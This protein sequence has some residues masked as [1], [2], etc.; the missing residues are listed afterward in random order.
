MLSEQVGSVREQPRS[1]IVTSSQGSHEMIANL[2][3][4]ELGVQHALQNI[5][6]FLIRPLR[7]QFLTICYH[8]IALQMHCVH[9]AIQQIAVLKEARNREFRSAEGNAQNN[10]L[11]DDIIGPVDEM[12]EPFNPLT[13]LITFST[14]HPNHE[15]MNHVIGN[16]VENVTDVFVGKLLIGGGCEHFLEHEV[17]MFRHD[18]QVLLHVR[19]HEKAAHE[20]TISLV[21]ITVRRH[22]TRAECG[23]KFLYILW[24][25][26]KNVAVGQHLLHLIGVQ[27]HD[28][29]FP[30]RPVL[31]DFAVRLGMPTQKLGRQYTILHQ[32]VSYHGPWCRSRNVSQFH[33]PYDHVHRALNDE[34][35]NQRKDDTEDGHACC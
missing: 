15:F 2:E 13:A 8:I 28:H 23:S 22:Q 19:S 20:L 4:G 34:R 29:W 26:D 33:A 17:G 32:H 5:I 1:R 9:I 31:E 24:S 3:L 35:G 7:A 12:R 25:L 6:R 10:G 30:A 21:L 16:V 27:D 11:T 14:I 18:W